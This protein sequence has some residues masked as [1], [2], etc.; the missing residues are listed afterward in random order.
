MPL[1]KYIFLLCLNSF[2]AL[3]SWILNLFQ[4]QFRFPFPRSSLWVKGFM[5][6]TDNLVKPFY[7]P[8]FYY[9]RFLIIVLDKLQCTHIDQ[10]RSLL[11]SCLLLSVDNDI[12]RLKNSLHL[13]LVLKTLFGHLGR[14][15]FALHMQNKEML[16]QNSMHATRK[17][18]NTTCTKQQNLQCKLRR[19]W[20]CTQTVCLTHPLLNHLKL[21]DLSLSFAGRPRASHRL[22]V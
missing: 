22:L 11:W 18:S 2:S 15:M 13:K 5:G 3:V 16:L 6:V 1:L 19:D 21:R 4:C 20:L 14:S 7:V 8:V 9:R 12:K 10:T 17:S